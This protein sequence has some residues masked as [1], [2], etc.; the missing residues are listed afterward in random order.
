MKC[1]FFHNSGA[2]EPNI[3]PESVHYVGYFSNH[4][5]SMQTVMQLQMAT[6]ETTLTS[7]LTRAS[8]HCRR[9]HLWNRLHTNSTTNALSFPELVGPCQLFQSITLVILVLVWHLSHSQMYLL[10]TVTH[11]NQFGANNVLQFLSTGGAFNFDANRRDA[12]GRF[13]N[14]R[15]S[16][17]RKT[18]KSSGNKIRE[19]LSTIRLRWIRTPRHPPGK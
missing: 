13:D 9:D 19:S 17:V 14:P 7:S 16:L 15:I 5:Q 4:E 6:T 1:L 12:F 11:I 2:G 8:S 3:I 18:G 10:M